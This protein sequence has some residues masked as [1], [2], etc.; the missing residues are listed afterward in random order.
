MSSLTVEL[1]LLSPWKIEALEG[2]TSCL[3]FVCWPARVMAGSG[4]R[5]VLTSSQT[6][7]GLLSCE[8][9]RVSCQDVISSLNMQGSEGCLKV[10]RRIKTL[11]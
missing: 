8:R 6:P 9:R 10:I 7:W 2:R 3:G 1:Q 11:S 4:V 5:A